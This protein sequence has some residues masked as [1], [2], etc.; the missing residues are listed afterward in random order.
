MKKFVAM[1]MAIVMVA[2]LM[3]GCGGNNGGSAS[4]DA[5]RIGMTGPLT[6][7][8][9]V[10]GQAVK[11]GME[12]AVEEINAKADAE[13]GLKIEFKAEDDVSDNEKATNAYNNLMDWDMQIFAGAVTTG[14][15]LTLAPKTVEDNIFMMTPS[16]SGVDVPKAGDNV[17]QMCFT[18][19]N[20]GAASAELIKG[21]NLGTKVG[22]LYD[23]TT[24]Y[25]DGIKKSFEEAAAELGIEVAAVTSFDANTADYKTQLQQCKDAGCDLVFMPIYAAQAVTVLSNANEMA[26]KPVFLGCDGMDGVLTQENFD[27]TLAEGLIMMT[28]FAADATDDATVS[29][30]A[31]YKEKSG[32]E[33]PNQFAADGYD[34]IYAVYAGCVA[35]GLDGKTAAA[36]VCAALKEYFTTATFNGLTGTGMTWDAEGLVS[37][38]PA[39]VEVVNGAYVS[40]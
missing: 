11:W 24:D 23:S 39:A 20:Q 8:N 35:K 36:D 9:A 1:M 28:P 33:I 37:K 4:G 38:M 7:D 26:Y 10:Y 12:I 27:K 40:K 14:P 2:G 3:A 16:A 25:S 22:I 32:G 17:F 5:I 13:G 31:K 6:G 21:Q 30:V 18:D 34:V 29:F 15:S 19:P